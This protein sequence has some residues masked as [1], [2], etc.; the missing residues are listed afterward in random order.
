MDTNLRELLRLLV[1][2]GKLTESQVDALLADAHLSTT[3]LHSLHHIHVAKEPIVLGQLAGCLASVKSNATQIV[4]S[5]ERDHLVHRVP[6][7][8]DRRC[9]QIKMTP[10]GEAAY[11]RGNQVVDGLQEKLDSALSREEQTE[12]FAL[13]SRLSRALDA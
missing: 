10:E 11:Q 8:H 12:L 6:A 3:K 5:L 13:L 4:D 9:I 1:L 7:A 2:C